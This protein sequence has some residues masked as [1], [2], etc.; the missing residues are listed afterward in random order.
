MFSLQFSRIP[1]FYSGKRRHVKTPSPKNQAPSIFSTFLFATKFVRAT[2]HTQSPPPI[3]R[4]PN[5]ESS[6][7]IYLSSEV[8]TCTYEARK[9]KASNGQPALL[10][11]SMLPFLRLQHFS[12]LYHF[13]G[14]EDPSNGWLFWITAPC[15][16]P[17]PSKIWI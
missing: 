8:Q 9:Q 17:L 4:P 11:L 6:L 13:L 12:P 7:K 16:G 5:A 1:C 3:L 10:H 2:R 14:G 15:C